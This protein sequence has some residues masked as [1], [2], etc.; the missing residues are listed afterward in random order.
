MSHRHIVLLGGSFDP[1]HVGHLQMARSAQAHCMADEVWFVPVGLPW[2]KGGTQATG[3]QRT[4]MANIAIEGAPSWR[5]E[6]CEVL[7]EGPSYTIDTLESLTEA[8]PDDRFTLLMGADQLEKLP[9]WRHWASLFDH[10]VIGVVERG[11]HGDIHIPAALQPFHQAGRIIRV[12]MPLVTLSS[13]D[14]RHWL[15][16]RH[17]ANPDIAQTARKRLTNSIPEKVL[18]YIEENGLYCGKIASD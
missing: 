14:I 11:G 1:I 16:Q 4:V 3:S 5:V 6:P 8:H 7:R 13:T 9:T 18:Q 12:P 2:Q 10:A 15:Q 17:H